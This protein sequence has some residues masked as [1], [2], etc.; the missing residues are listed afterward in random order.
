MS[1]SLSFS[2]LK[3]ICESFYC[4]CVAVTVNLHVTLCTRPLVTSRQIF[5]TS[6][7]TVFN[8]FYIQDVIKLNYIHWELVGPQCCLG[9]GMAVAYALGWEALMLSASFVC[10]PAHRHT[11]HTLQIWPD[12]SLCWASHK[13]YTQPPPKIIKVT[14]CEVHMKSYI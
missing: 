1:N 5:R 9:A 2:V 6:N 3:Y 8:L 4:T 10:Q 14:Q 12:T 7:K 13:H 11:H